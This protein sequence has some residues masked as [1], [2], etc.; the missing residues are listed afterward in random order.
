MKIDFAIGSREFIRRAVPDAAPA[1]G[2]KN[3][4]DLCALCG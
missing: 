3:L 1:L 2:E 4:R